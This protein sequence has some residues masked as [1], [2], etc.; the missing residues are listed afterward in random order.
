MTAGGEGLALIVG[1]R[2]SGSTWLLNLLALHPEV[3]AVRETHAFQLAATEP[4]PARRTERLFR[5]TPWAAG[6]LARWPLQR[7]LERAPE[8]VRRRRAALRTPPAERPASLLDLP[9]PAA[10]AA[11]RRLARTA[12]P[13]A[14]CRSLFGLLA[15]RL[16]PPRL[17]VEKSPS[18]VFHLAAVRALFPRAKLVAVHRDGRDVVVS[19]R[20][21]RQ[22]YEAGR[23]WQLDE[24][25]RAWRRALEAELAFAREAPLFTC[26]YEDLHARGPEVVAALLDHL[27]LARSP[28]LVADLVERASF[29]RQTGRNPGEE[30]RGRFLRKGVVGDWKH[31]FTPDHRATFKHLAGDLLITL[32][33]ERDLGR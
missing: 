6:G 20:F 18:H 15:D 17:L 33:Y 2:K 29:R 10:L 21:F 28:A 23:G 13:D 4:D 8:A 24:S 1:Q 3:R 30:A 25:V 22:A 14:W 32:G 9:L 31:H 19:D 26:S 12:D 11:R 16:A 7:L 5:R 27:G